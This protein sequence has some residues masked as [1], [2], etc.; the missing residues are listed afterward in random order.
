MAPTAILRRLG[1][2]SP[3]Y[4]YAYH[5]DCD[6]AR[7]ARAEGIV[8]VVSPQLQIVHYESSGTSVPMPL[9][10]LNAANLVSFMRDEP[11]KNVPVG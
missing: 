1:P 11:S 2:F 3:R 9:L 8:S 7:R 4:F 5:E 6:L 10:A